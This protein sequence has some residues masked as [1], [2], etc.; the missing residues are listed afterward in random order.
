METSAT[1]PPA[2]PVGTVPPKPRRR[3][4]RKIAWGAGILVAVVAALPHAVALGFVR[5]DAEAALSEMLGVPCRI[6]RIGFSWFTGFGVQGVEIANPPDFRSDQPALRIAR[7]GGDIGVLDVFGGRFDFSGSAAGLQVRIEEDERGRNNFAVLFGSG[8][9][10][11]STSTPPRAPSGERPPRPPAPPRLEG[12]GRLQFDLQV[13]DALLEIRRRG[14]LLESLTRVQ[15]RLHKS[16]AA[17]RIGVDFDADLQPIAGGTRPGRLEARLEADAATREAAGTL[18]AVDL[19]LSRYAPLLAAFLPGRVDKIAGI[20]N[21]TLTFRH[22]RDGAVRLGGDLVIDGP[23]LAGPALAGM[24]VRADRWSLSP[25]IAIGASDADPAASL[26]SDAFAADLGF[27]TL[28]GMSAADAAAALGRDGLLALRCELDLDAIAAFGGPVPTWLAGSGGRAQCIVGV[29][30]E[31]LTGDRANWLDA[32]VATG[33][34]AAKRIAAFGCELTTPGL[35]VHL[36]GGTLQLATVESSTLNQ[37]PLQLTAT[38]DTRTGP[39]GTA[40]VELAWQDGQLGGALHGALRYAVPLFAGLDPATADL[41]GIADLRFDLHGPLRPGPDQNWLQF[42]NEW[43]GAGHV[44]LREASLRP[45]SALRGLLQPLGAELAALQTD[46]DRLPI[47]G[48]T[49]DFTLRAGFVECR[50]G[51]WL[52]RGQRIGLSGRIGLDGVVD[53]GADLSSL[54]AAHRD[55]ARVLEALGGKLPPARLAGTVAAPQLALP[56][57]AAAVR[58]AAQRQLEQQGKDLLR[59]SIDEL[60]RRKKG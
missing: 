50:L 45:A 27:A 19:D 57:L 54:L 40:R 20:G 15:C 9:V 28:R 36:A 32:V 13:Q 55:G 12:L 11:T 53:Y 26:R 44:G 47:D 52:A 49:N 4:W 5:A 59:R 2:A 39:R 42:A 21:G 8:V 31:A 10:V 51:E 30:A 25:R 18:T 48:F 24:H 34:A 14:E 37:G 7:L 22:E 41:R 1:S 29:P 46:G 43:A 58:D 38:L 35:V 56:D 23:Q 60:F 17:E 6:E 33:S 16:F 3:I